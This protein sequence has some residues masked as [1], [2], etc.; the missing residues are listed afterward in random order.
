MRP[1][2]IHK[3][4]AEKKKTADE[5]FNTYLEEGKELEE[6]FTKRNAE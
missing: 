4:T 1:I 2:F 6:V 5:F 3:Y